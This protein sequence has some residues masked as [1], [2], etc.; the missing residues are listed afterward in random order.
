MKK[1]LLQTERK[2]DNIFIPK[3]PANPWPELKHRLSTIGYDLVTADD[4]SLEDCERIIFLDYVSLGEPDAQ[5]V[6]IKNAIKKL[7]GMKVYER[8]PARALYREGLRAGLRDKMVFNIWEGKAVSPLNFDSKTLEKFDR[9]LTWN[10]DLVDN[11]KFFKFFLPAPADIQPTKEV[12]F[13]HKKLLVNISYNKYSSY[14][15]E[16]YSERR[17]TIAYFDTHY[18]DDFDLFGPRWNTAITR[19]QILFPFL[20]R[21]YSTYR[22]YVEDRQETLSKYKFSLSYENNADANGYI[23]DKI[24]D[25]LRA[26][27]VPIYLGAPNIL[28]Y[29]PAEA[30]IDRRKFNSDED[31]GI[32]LKNMHEEEY[33]SYI[34]AGKN[35][36]QSERYAG[37]STTDFCDR[38]MK[39][40][41]LKKLT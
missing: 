14:K 30:F 28:D 11:I 26:K 17:K 6:R 33:Q 15:A 20:V 38:I 18:P 32:F 7:L 24:F 40:L 35:Y 21:T 1:I 9:V 29:I 4:N 16:L 23:T 13:A 31:L 12:A 39:V 8:L 22:G 34:S 37:F 5:T 36:L 3:D 27:T 25:A 41:D 19:L 2:N 10:D